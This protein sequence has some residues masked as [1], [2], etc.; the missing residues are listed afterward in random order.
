MTSARELLNWSFSTDRFEQGAHSLCSPDVRRVIQ[1]A[2]QTLVTV[3]DSNEKINIQMPPDADQLYQQ[4][5]SLAQ[6]NPQQCQQVFGSVKKTRK[7][8]YILSYRPPKK[9]SIINS[10]YNELAVSIIDSNWKTRFLIPLVYTLLHQW[11]SPMIG[12]LR[13]LIA[14]K[15]QS[16]QTH[17]K[18][19]L[20]LKEISRYYIE[21]KGPF[22]LGASLI[23]K[24]LQ[25]QDLWKAYS[26][27]ENMID[28]PYFSDVCWSYVCVLLKQKKFWSKIDSVVDFLVK[29][30]SIITSKKVLSELIHQ[31][32]NNP[33]P[34]LQEHIKK[35]AFKLIGD[36]ENDAYWTPWP[37]ATAQEKQHLKSAQEILNGWIVQQFIEIFF[38]KLAMDPERKNFWQKYIKHVRRFKIFGQSDIRRRFE[39]DAR[40][41]PYLKGRFGYLDGDANQNALVMIMKGYYLIEFSYSGSAFYAYPATQH[42]APDLGNHHLHINEIKPPSIRQQNK[43]II[44]KGE[45]GYNYSTGCYEQTYEHRKFGKLGHSGDWQIRL[46]VWLEHYMGI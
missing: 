27:E 20:K 42:D 16:L 43:S 34:L 19:L 32:D 31:V 46:A 4:F 36:P 26:F 5:I 45:S 22:L 18:S 38:D 11:D 3:F 40:T 33:D 17:R 9:K 7:L 15:V 28:A 44:K 35:T 25:L 2:S 41:E 23:E 1:Q 12:P 30:N 8:T 14:R 21:E 10:H 37:R 13:E 29:H 6:A 39:D 24:G